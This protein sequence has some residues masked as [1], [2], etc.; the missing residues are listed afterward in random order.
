MKQE[1]HPH[2]KTGLILGKF[3]PPHLGHQ[4][5]IDFA[6]GFVEYLTILVWSTP[7]DPIPGDLRYA[8]MLDMCADANVIH[9]TDENPKEPQQDRDFFSL[10]YKTIRRVLPTGPDYF[11]ANEEYGERFARMLGAGYIPVDRH[12]PVSGSLIRENP[13]ATWPYIPA[14]V[15]PYFVRRICIIGPESTGRS[16]LAQR[17]AA[18]Y[19]TVSVNEYARLI[20]ETKGGHYHLDDI[21]L[22]A[23]GQIASEDALARQANWLLFC[24]TDLLTTVIW[25]EIL[26]D[27]CPDWI[28]AEAEKRRYDLYLLTD[29][30]DPWAE[31]HQRLLSAERQLFFERCLGELESRNKSYVQ[32]SGS[33]KQRFEQAC[34]AVDQVVSQSHFSQT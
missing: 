7:S 23:R 14:C 21:S 18:H 10:W 2:S 20:L 27:D 3:M 1:H 28:R 32:I 15:R 9:I 8:W 24:D 5:L 22:I 12:I 11:L 34:Q 30:D 31:D 29:I 4:Y 26:Y 17:L 33:W 16:T 19:G 6:R 13:M 25:S